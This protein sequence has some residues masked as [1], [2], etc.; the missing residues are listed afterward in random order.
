MGTCARN[1]SF[2]DRGSN[3]SSVLAEFSVLSTSIS[4]KLLPPT[5][6]R[7]QSLTLK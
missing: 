1:E 7:P 5:I 3:G 4:A 6:S 2:R